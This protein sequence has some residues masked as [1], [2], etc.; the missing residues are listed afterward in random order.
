MLTETLSVRTLR[1]TTYLMRVQ[2]FSVRQCL[3]QEIN[4]EGGIAYAT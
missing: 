1:P 4:V 2:L 3:V